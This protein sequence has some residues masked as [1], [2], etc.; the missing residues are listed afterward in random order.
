VAKTTK[1]LIKM[2]YTQPKTINAHDK[3]I[4]VLHLIVHTLSNII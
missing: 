3:M 2:V 1:Q 4:Q